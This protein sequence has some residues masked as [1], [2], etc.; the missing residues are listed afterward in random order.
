[1]P[2][3]LPDTHDHAAPAWR[4]RDWQMLIG[5]GWRS[6][7]ATRDVTDP[8]T[9]DVIATVPEADAGHVDAA[10]A[11]ARASFD[12]GVWHRKPADE[13]AQILWRIADAIDARA[14]ELAVVEARNQGGPHA[15]VR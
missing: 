4:D 7:G 10:V 5:D 6:A 15:G 13:R 9:G 2:L 14:D 12:A 1:M 3:L 8:G 11:A